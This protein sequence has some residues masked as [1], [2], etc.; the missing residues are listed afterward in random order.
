M[1]EYLIL[2]WNKLNYSLFE[3]SINEIVKNESSKSKKPKHSLDFYTFD[4]HQSGQNEDIR[5]YS[6]YQKWADNVENEWSEI[7]SNYL[8]KDRV[9]MR[10]SSYDSIA[11]SIES[12]LSVINPV[13]ITKELISDYLDLQNILLYLKIM[14]STTNILTMKEKI[15]WSDYAVFSELLQIKMKHYEQRLHSIHDIIHKPHFDMECVAK[16]KSKEVK[17]GRGLLQKSL[18]LNYKIIHDSLRKGLIDI[19]L[20]LPFL[21]IAIGFVIYFVF[22]YH[23]IWPMIAVCILFL[24]LTSYR[25]IPL[26]VS[27]FHLSK[28]RKKMKKENPNNVK[29]V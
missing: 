17:C 12:K 27:T 28:L 16:E 8:M 23:A 25:I 14:E 21:I 1:G 22:D 29:I 7:Q 15:S 13:P 19:C 3:P 2:I 11:K 18:S 6:F 10:L 26:I 24:L 9:N 4:Y 5:C 20:I